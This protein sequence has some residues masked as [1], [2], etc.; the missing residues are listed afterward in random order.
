MNGIVKTT[1]SNG[2][3]YHKIRTDTERKPKHVCIEEANENECEFITQ[4][5]DPNNKRHI[6]FGYFKSF[7]DYRKDYG[8]S[9][10]HSYEIIS[11]DCKL[12]FDIE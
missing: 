3:F 11:R 6:K 9:N 2:V 4:F 8:K 1:V 10:V 12:Y 7:A 5:D